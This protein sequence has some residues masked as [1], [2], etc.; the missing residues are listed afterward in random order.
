MRVCSFV[1]E[2][3]NQNPC[4]ISAVVCENGVEVANFW[5]TS[6]NNKSYT[7]MLNEFATFLY[8]NA[9]DAVWVTDGVFPKVAAVFFDMVDSGLFDF[10]DFKTCLYDISTLLW[11]EKY[12]HQYEFYNLLH[13]V[14]CPVSTEGIELLDTA[15]KIAA[16]YMH[17]IQHQE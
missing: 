14:P 16:C 13:R 11:E 15:R 12:R 8:G 2:T 7:D 3:L 17:L 9:L 4:L 6:Y 10:E 5:T 1:I